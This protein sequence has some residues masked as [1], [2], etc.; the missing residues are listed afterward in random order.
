MSDDT[1]DKELRFHEKIVHLQS[2]SGVA[3]TKTGN[4]VS[5]KSR[6]L[7]MMLENIKPTLKELNLILTITHDIISIN[8]E[9]FVKA[10]ACIAD[11][12]ERFIDSVAFS[13]I[14]KATYTTVENTVIR[15]S[16]RV[17]K[18]GKQTPLIDS[19]EVTTK[20]TPNNRLHGQ[21]DPQVVG[22][23]MSY[24]GKRAVETLLAIDENED[25]DSIPA[26][27]PKAP[28]KSKVELLNVVNEIIPLLEQNKEVNDFTWNKFDKSF[29]DFYGIDKENKRE[30]E[31]LK[32]IIGA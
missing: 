24:A 12:N 6:S 16:I 1:K 19:R 14:P 17:D 15:E 29:I 21:Q 4:G 22:S 13:L 11:E 7:T 25:I 8:D 28:V 31:N 23:C 27:Q 2:V 32:K 5:F 30:L 9:T 20:T 3:K 26:E 18:D 10:T